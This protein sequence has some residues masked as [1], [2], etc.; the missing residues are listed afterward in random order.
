MQPP[1]KKSITTKKN[2]INRQ[3]TPNSQRLKS[4]PGVSGCFLAIPTP[5]SFRT[6]NN[7]PSKGSI[8]SSVTRIRTDKPRHFLE[9]VP[10]LLENKIRLEMVYIH[11]EANLADASSRQRVLDMWFLILREPNLRF[12]R[13]SISRRFLW[14]SF[15]SFPFCTRHTRKRSCTWSSRPWVHR[16]AQPVCLQKGHSRSAC[17]VSRLPGSR[18]Y[19]DTRGKHYSLLTWRVQ[20]GKELNDLS[21]TMQ[22]VEHLRR[23]VW[24]S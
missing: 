24:G 6:T 23:K 17:L 18:L 15:S 16:S 19:C 2:A 21:D 14:T 9:L 3:W 22:I 7:A 8:R 1:L 5:T 11:S 12:E 13:I 4:T 10:W 20:K